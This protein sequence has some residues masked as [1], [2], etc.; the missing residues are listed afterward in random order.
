MKIVIRSL[1][2]GDNKFY[3]QIYLTNS[4]YNKV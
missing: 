3:P 1:F 4:T 2:K